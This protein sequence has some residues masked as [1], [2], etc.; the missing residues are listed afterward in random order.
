MA[1]AL[2]DPP[3][4]SQLASCLT[5]FAMTSALAEKPTTSTEEPA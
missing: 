4:I 5:D 3:A 1:A 2:T